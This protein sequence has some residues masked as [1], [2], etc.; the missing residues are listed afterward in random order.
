M[1]GIDCPQCGRPTDW[2]STTNEWQYLCKPCEARFNRA[3]QKMPPFETILR[4]G[5]GTDDA[6]YTSTVPFGWTP[7]YGD[8]DV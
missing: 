2:G 8:P 4:F 3:G 7:K 6:P 1:N 5:K